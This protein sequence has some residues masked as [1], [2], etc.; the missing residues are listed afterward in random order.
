VLFVMI[1]AVSKGFLREDVFL[2]DERTERLEVVGR[3][4]RG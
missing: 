1:E 4:W 3:S 2:R